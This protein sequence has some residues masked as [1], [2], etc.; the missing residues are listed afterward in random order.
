MQNRFIG[1]LVLPV[2]SECVMPVIA[3]LP[4]T[5]T[6]PLPA[7]HANR[8]HESARCGVTV[9]SSPDDGASRV[10]PSTCR[11]Q[12]SSAWCVWAPDA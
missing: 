4:D 5:C 12:P 2:A 6:R 1:V 3:A 10:P 11:S 9:G 8:A 7:S